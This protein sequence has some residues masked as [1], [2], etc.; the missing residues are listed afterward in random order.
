MSTPS[1]NTAILV[2]F[3]L[4]VPSAGLF[5]TV[6]PQSAVLVM[7]DSVQ[8]EI[9]LLPPGTAN[10]LEVYAQGLT[11]ASGTLELSGTASI[12]IDLNP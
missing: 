3:D 4:N 6:A 12:R 1:G 5:Q 7:G 10:G 2:G 8:V 11:N 9:P